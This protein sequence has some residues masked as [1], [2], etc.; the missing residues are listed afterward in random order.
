MAASSTTAAG[1]PRKS[2]LRSPVTWVIILGVTLAGGAYILWR[3]NQSAAASSSGANTTSG[4]DTTGTTDDSGALSTLQTEIADLQSSAS[5][6][7]AT[8][9]GGTS[10]GGG[11]TSG[12]G[13]STGG[14]TS[15]GGSASSP[16]KVPPVITV[17]N[18]GIAA[19]D[20]SWTGVPGATAYVLDITGPQG[21]HQASPTVHGT[22]ARVDLPAGKKNL[23][24]KVRATNAAGAGPWSATRTFSVGGRPAVKKAA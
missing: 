23:K 10:T 6:G 5:Q 18:P 1:K 12:G 8:T 3:R 22:H 13:T 7:T 21:S 16:P 15:G 17:V 11:S 2:M 9:G 20:I 24:V 14:G 19:A 4:T